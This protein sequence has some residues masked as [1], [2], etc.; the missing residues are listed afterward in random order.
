MERQRSLD[1][2]LHSMNRAT[3][4]SPGFEDSKPIIQK[5]N[6][7]LSK[8]PLDPAAVIKAFMDK[9]KDEDDLEK[10]KP[11]LGSGERFKQLS[12]KLSKKGVKD[13]DALAA[14]IGRKKLGKNRFQK[15]AAK[16]K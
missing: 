11:K 7:S 3:S 1:G 12:S 6:P 10:K 8:P 9:D 15:L 5:S 16:G 14:T 4:I 2:S 13:P